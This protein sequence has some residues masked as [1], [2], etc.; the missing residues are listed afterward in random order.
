MA[1][2][3]ALGV[4]G[5]ACGPWSPRWCSRRSPIR[6]ACRGVDGH[7]R[8]GLFRH[9]QGS[10]DGARAWCPSPRAASGRSRR[11]RPAGA[12][13]PAGWRC[14]CRGS[15]GSS[16]RRRPQQHAARC[17]PA[18]A[19][20][21]WRRCRWP[22]PVPPPSMVVT[23]EASASSICCGQ[24]KWMWRVDRAGG[25]D[26]PL[27]G[28]DLGARADDDVHARLHVGVAGLADGGDAAAAQADVGFHD[29]PVVDDHRVGDHA[30]DRVLR[31]GPLT[32]W[33]C[34]MP[35]RMV[36]PPPNFTSS[37]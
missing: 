11:R 19:C 35:S 28:D 13:P 26:H 6:S 21:W 22:G 18:R 23:P 36:L 9:V 30:V 7:L 2:A 10:C 37:P 24:M 4:E 5:D 15:R 3:R 33:L 16:G 12:A 34:P 29:A 27:A 1:A 14:L 17:W 31:P 20:R 8:V 32:R 25:D